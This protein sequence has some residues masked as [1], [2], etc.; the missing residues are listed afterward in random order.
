MN[1]ARGW[2]LTLPADEYDRAAVE[3]G[4][5]P[6][7]AYLGQ[8]EQGATTGYK[9]WQLYLE[10]RT[11][12]RFETLRNKFPKAHL[13]PRRGT[14]AQAVAY[15]TKPETSLGEVLM[16]GTINLDDQGKRSDLE[17][18]QAAI[19]KEGLTPGQVIREWP[20]AAR[21]ER[22]LNALAD[23]RDEQRFGRN[24]R[25]LEVHYLWGSTG[26]GKTRSVVERYSWDEIYR[27][28]NYKNP[29]DLYRGE[30]VL[31]LDEFNSQLP[32][33]LMLNL[34]DGYPLRLPAR[35]SDK[36]A[37]FSV[38]WLIANVPWTSQY[39]NTR[40]NARRRWDA[41]DRR[42]HTIAEMTSEGVLEFERGSLE[43][44]SMATEPQARAAG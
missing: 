6:Y 36:W 31:V 43:D 37:G 27:V 2:M 26:V 40:M 23:A 35:Y 29:F 20:G 24:W 9:H 19:M 41:L 14:R 17:T 5:A 10:H 4:L 7:D 22:M 13:E 44:I 1:K 16:K 33:E 25:T 3:A 38:V 12:I 8:L 18:Y 42:V 30:R 39:K 34:L 11:P 32:F 21:F 28:T 15:V